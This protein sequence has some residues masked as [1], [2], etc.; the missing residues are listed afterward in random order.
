VTEFN[1][2]DKVEYVEDHDGRNA[3]TMGHLPEEQPAPAELET[4]EFADIQVGDT[5]KRTKTSESGTVY[6]VVGVVAHKS[7]HYAEDEGY[8]HV[9]YSKYDDDDEEVTLKLVS[10]PEPELVV[11]EPKITDNKPVGAQVVRKNNGDNTV[12]TK[13]DEDL[14]STLYLNKDGSV[15]ASYMTWTDEEI[16]N[17]VEGYETVTA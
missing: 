8:K 12:F 13:K 6:T 1:V 16:Q 10:R 11:V 14:W 9:L 4:I 2:G 17:L 5:I 7:S 15:H 3:G